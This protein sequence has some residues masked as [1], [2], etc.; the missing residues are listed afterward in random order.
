MKFTAI[1]YVYS[2]LGVILVVLPQAAQDFPSAAPIL[3]AA[4]SGLVALKTIIGLVAPSV[5][6]SANAAAVKP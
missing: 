2:A 6:T 1:H 3:A 4:M 5:S